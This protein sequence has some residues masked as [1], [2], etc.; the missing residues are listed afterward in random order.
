MPGQGKYTAYYNNAFAGNEEKKTRLE[1][2]YSNGVFTAAGPYNQV[3]VIRT[4]NE[5]ILAIQNPESGTEFL[6]LG[7]INMFPDGV[8]M[9]FRGTSTDENAADISTVEWKKAGD[10]LNPYVPDVRSPGAAP[11]IDLS[12]TSTDVVTVNADASEGDSRDNAPGDLADI[13]RFNPNY[14]PADSDGEKYDNKGTRNPIHTGKKIHEIASVSVDRPLKL[15]D[16]MR[17]KDEQ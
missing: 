2:I 14:D 13:E 6:Q 12:S 16:S 8:F 17:F 1:A 11:G 7:D 4:G 9:D 5:R 15:G 3:D 10:P